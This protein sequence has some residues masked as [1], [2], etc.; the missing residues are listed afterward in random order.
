MTKVP[1]RTKGHDQSKV[2]V[3]TYPGQCTS[4]DQVHSSQAGFVAHLKG[5]LTMGCYYNNTIFVDHFSRLC[6]IHLMT[7]QTSAMT[8]QAKQAFHCR[9]DNLFET[10]SLNKPDTMIPSNW[11]IPAGLEGP[12]QLPSVEQS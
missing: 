11:Q 12:N 10:V 7:A 2:F 6:Y 4:V 8:L 5:Y 3:A 9:F 1:W